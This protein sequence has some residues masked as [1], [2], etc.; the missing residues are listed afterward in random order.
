[1]VG[2]VTARF[3]IVEG[4]FT[5]EGSCTAPSVRPRPS[6]RKSPYFK[7]IANI[8]E[9]SVLHW[10]SIFLRLLQSGLGVLF[11]GVY[12]DRV[13]VEFGAGPHARKLACFDN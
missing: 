7:I 5:G 3:F 6:A 13:N 9:I 12:E 11:E 10:V 2:P 1:M 4:I 8:T